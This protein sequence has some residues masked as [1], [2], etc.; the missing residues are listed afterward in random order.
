MQIE[1]RPAVEDDAFAASQVLNRSITEC[2]SED[3][4]D[5][6]GII[7]A[8]VRNKTPETVRGWL[9][10]GYLFCIVAVASGQVAGFAACSTSG[11]V[12][13]CY[14]LPEV[15]FTGTGRAM[16]R[17]LE[18]LAV[19]RGI[20][21]LH[22]TSTLTARPFYL[23]NGFEVIGPSVIAFGMAGIPMTKHLKRDMGT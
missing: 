21:T 12:M 9:S 17:S 5:D 7:A 15:R 22:L 6:S 13:L 20:Q 4:Q 2:C 1:I 23:R 10:N 3:H 16:L 8:W 19:K 18:R 11:E 14:V